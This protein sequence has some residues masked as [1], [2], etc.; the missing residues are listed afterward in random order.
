MIELPQYLGNLTVEIMSHPISRADLK[1]ADL[2]CN[3]EF[4]TT[5]EQQRSYVL[6]HCAK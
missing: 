3:F 6:Q 1:K 4:V 2:C 5:Q